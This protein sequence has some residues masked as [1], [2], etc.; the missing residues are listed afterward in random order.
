MSVP[1][2]PSFFDVD[3]QIGMNVCALRRRLDLSSAVV[4][5]LLKIP[6]AQFERAEA[7][8]VRFSAEQIFALSRLL[9]VPMSQLYATPEPEAAR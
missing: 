4:A 5:D 2:S 7:G 1:G 3:K 9:Q 8:T 6:P